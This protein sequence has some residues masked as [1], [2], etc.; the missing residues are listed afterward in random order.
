MRSP[1][2]QL[3]LALNNPNPVDTMTRDELRAY[4]DASSLQQHMSFDDCMQN[5]WAFSVFRFEIRT[6]LL[7]K[8]GHV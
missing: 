6:R 7:R 1:K 4:W 3:P 2:R 5:G 8:V